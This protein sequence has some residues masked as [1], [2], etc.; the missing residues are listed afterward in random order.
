MRRLDV[1]TAVAVVGCVVGTTTREMKVE[2]PRGEL[3]SVDL[4]L[5]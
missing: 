4:V 3:R 2:I 5:G 1:S